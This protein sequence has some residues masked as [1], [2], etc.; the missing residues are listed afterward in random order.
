MTNIPAK[1]YVVPTQPPLPTRWSG[2]PDA[3]LNHDRRRRPRAQLELPVRVRW[4]GPFGLETEITHTCNASRDGLLVSSQQPR[5]HGSLVWATFPFDPAA[6]FTESETPG[7]VVRS[8]S[9]SGD[10]CRIAISF[11]PGEPVSPV[12]GSTAKETSSHSKRND[13]RGQ[14]R[15]P[16][17]YLVRVTRSASRSN[18][19]DLPLESPFRSED[20]MTVDVSP[21]GMIFCT[22]RIYSASEQL[23]IAAQMG[24]KLSNERR[25][26]V[27]GVRRSASDSPLSYVAVEYLS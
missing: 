13:R 15:I 22:L 18:G 17:A 5:Q 26:Q 20:A 4:L 25:A 6:A 24:L 8:E 11:Q 2:A 21:N 23:L 9:A 27:V 10:A 12:D 16:L 3:A 14:P 19:S 1:P 7:K